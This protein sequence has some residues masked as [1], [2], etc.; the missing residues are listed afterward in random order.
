MEVARHLEAP[1]PP[2]GRPLEGGVGRHASRAVTLG[3]VM[4]ERSPL[5]WQSARTR[6]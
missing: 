4:R 3:G 1:A 6:R 2:A 5:A